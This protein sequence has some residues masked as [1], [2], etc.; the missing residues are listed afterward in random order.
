MPD[1]LTLKNV[2]RRFGKIL[3]VNGLSMSVPDKSVCAFVGANG[4]GKTTTFSLVGEFIRLHAG[5]IE[6]F[7]IPLRTFR[8][9][10]GIIGLLPQD[11][12]YFEDRT[13]WRQ[14]FLFARLAGMAA[15]EAEGEVLRVLKLVRLDDKAGATAGDLSH[16]MRVRLGVAQA[17]IGQPPLIMLDEPTA[18]LDPRMQVEFRETIDALRGKT[19]IVISSHDLS[20]LQEMCDYCCMIDRGKLLRQGPMGQLLSGSVQ[21][22]TFRVVSLKAQ[23]AG[24][25]SLLPGVDIIQEDGQTFIVEFA[26]SKYKVPEV[27]RIVLAWLLNAGMEVL[28]VKQTRS[29]EKAFLE[30]TGH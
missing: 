25:E 3:A 22:L 1:A 24:L 21:S 18:G 2:T 13:V 23:L 26:L 10:G 4:A 19:T 6:V 12:Q 20:Q 17:L 5:S 15:V 9:R 8:A 27:N 30:A 16:G 28:E 29:L 14:L 11:M 7:G